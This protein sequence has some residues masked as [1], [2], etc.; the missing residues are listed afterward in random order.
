MECPGTST[1]TTS[2]K[3]GSVRVIAQPFY[4]AEHSNPDEDEYVFGY[5]I[6]I[7]NEGPPVGPPVQLLW[8]RW[9]ITDADGLVREV[10]GSGVIGE[11]PEL[12]P[13]DRFSYQSFCPL[14]T[15]TGTMEGSYTFQAELDNGPVM[16]E[17]RVAPFEFR[18][19]D[20]GGPAEAPR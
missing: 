4:L 3:H 15:P 11:Q 18:A 5:R 14:P 9:S 10:Q 20:T 8:R 7:S 1:C 2:W 13:A 19:L 17:V 6:E 12:A 16:F